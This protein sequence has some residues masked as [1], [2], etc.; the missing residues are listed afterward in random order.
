LV[1]CAIGCN[2]S[3]T[4]G[5]STTLASRTDSCSEE[6]AQAFH[7]VGKDGESAIRDI[8]RVLKPNGTLALI[9]NFEDRSVPWVAQLR[10]AY[11]QHEAGTP[12]VSPF[13][14]LHHLHSS[15]IGK[16]SKNKTDFHLSLR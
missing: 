10:D 12:Q 1:F 16:P 9:W 6:F 13:S 2:R 15:G 8:A 11:E 4:F 5:F 3:G 14:F 7:W